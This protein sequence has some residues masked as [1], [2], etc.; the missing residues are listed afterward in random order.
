MPKRISNKIVLVEDLEQQALVRRYLERCG[1]GAGLRLVR[2]PAKGPGG[3]GE[4]Y[5]R[6]QYPL[7][8]QACRSSLGRRKSALL[9]VVIDADLETTQ[10]RSQQLSNALVAM[11][12]EPRDNREP[13]VVLI[14]KRHIESW[15]RALQ[16]KPVN[17]HDSY[18]DPA[19]TPKEI[20]QA[21]VTL[22]AWTRPNAG[23]GPTSP[24]S[25]T[26][27]IPEWQKIPS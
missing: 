4:Q 3:S 9:T 15:I 16:G 22:Y 20:L 13:I 23:P 18:K 26:D 1:H 19:P 10:Y 14:P 12:M 7:Q 25:L 24:P 2:L 8:V 6:S 11:N 5:V 21:A 17:E 27:S